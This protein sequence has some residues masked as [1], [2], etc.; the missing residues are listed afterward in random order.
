VS[1]GHLGI[2]SLYYQNLVADLADLT[3]VEEL[4]SV[5]ILG[6]LG[7]NLFLEFELELNLAEL[8]MVIHRLGPDGLPVNAEN[9]HSEG[10]VLYRLPFVLQDNV[11]LV[12]SYIDEQPMTLCFDTG[13]EAVV[14]GTNLN[15][16]VYKSSL[17]LIGCLQLTGAN[18]SSLYV[19]YGKLRHVKFGRDFH[20]INVIIA[21]LKGLE[22]SYGNIDGI[23][24][25]DLIAE[26]I[27]C[28]NFKKKQIVL[29][30]LEQ[31]GQKKFLE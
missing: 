9:T 19:H 3:S 27:L 4:R 15:P 25:Y 23:L 31:P 29:K 28:I 17:Q 7:V 22:R 2:G 1:V 14:L 6:A 5:K 8:E 12:T 10:R 13:A 16:E 24:G 26:D 11:M 21:D 30:T 18:G 20:N